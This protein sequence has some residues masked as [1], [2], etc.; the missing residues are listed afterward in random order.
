MR[1][2]HKLTQSFCYALIGFVLVVLAATV[3]AETLGREGAG[4]LESIDGYLVLHLKGS[5]YEMGLQHGKLLRE[6]VRENMRFILNGKGNESLVQVGPLRATAKSLLP[7]IVEV[8]KPYVAA[9]YWDEMRGLAD[10]AE[11]KLEDVQMG[12]FIPE[13][14]H[15]SGFAVMN[16]ATA[17]GTLFHGRVLDYGVDMRLQEHAVLIIAEPKGGV[18]F[19][20]ISYAGFIG[21]VT[22]M[23]AQHI[24]I[25][26]MGGRGLGAWQGTPMSL[27]VREVL[28]TAKDLDA[29][30]EVFRGHKRTCEYYYVIAD[31][32]TNRAVGIAA[33]PENLTEIAPG[34]AHPRLPKPVADA[35]LL[36][37]GSRYDELVKRVQLQHG[38]LNADTAL[39]LMERPVEMRSNLQNVMFEPVCTRLW[40]ANASQAGEPA[41][42]QKYHAF[43][44][45][46]LLARRPAEQPTR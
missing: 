43:Q 23:N 32:K 5:P 25:G 2:A 33:T 12:N 21:S 27:L 18:P 34:K 40:V 37:A 7:G 20:N 45:T 16:A 26:E 9:K 31:G 22:G 14:F 1:R 36:S 38:K 17:D 4:W 19:A 6:H 39:H 29:A 44:L 41:A 11:L 46:E 30:V 35:V 28:E 8:Q 24:S 13:L 42:E 3:H 10:G 15:C